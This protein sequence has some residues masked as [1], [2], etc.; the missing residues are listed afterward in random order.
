[1]SETHPEYTVSVV[2]PA[3]NIGEYV[4]RAIESVLS[5]THKADEIIVVDDGSTDGTADVIKK[6]VPRVKYV[7]QENRGLAGARNTGIRESTCRWVAFLDGDDEWLPDFLDKQLSLLARNP[8]LVWSS[9]NYYSALHAEGRQAP[10]IQ[11][12]R[13]AD[14][15][16]GREHF[17]DFFTGYAL[18]IVGL[19]DTMVIRRDVI[20][21]A[22]MY[23]E[24]LR[25]AEDWD[26]WMRLAF[27]W[28]GI[29]YVK[30][31]I[32]IYNLDRPGSLMLATPGGEKMRV[33]CGL[34]DRHIRLAR[35][36][37]R[38]SCFK[39][40][41]EFMLRRWIRGLL[42]CKD[43]KEIIRQMLARYREMLPAW[44]RMWIR[45]LTVWPRVTA[46]I[47]H[48][49]SHVVRKLRLRRKV[50]SLPGR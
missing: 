47:C 29:G 11:P 25:F 28:P 41:A 40:C 17:E 39:P 24:R 22:G 33:N 10:I 32:A 4:G 30:E 44:Y 27:R 5:Q 9:S 7:H 18:G 31:P 45:A 38:Y 35:E 20:I 19:P 42:F 49:I 14:A 46:G 3:Y 15:M 50:V 2:I 6:Y 13:A 8:D 21:E 23:D 43:Q 16:D 36:S 12:N 48:A 34:M 1:M 26:M 37:G